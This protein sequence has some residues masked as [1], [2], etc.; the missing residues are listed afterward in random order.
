M[1]YDLALAEA[2]R[3]MVANGITT[4]YLGVSFTWEPGLRSS[5]GTRELLEAIEASRPKMAADA[6]I[7]LRF[8]IYHLEGLDTLKTW[9]ADGRLDLLSFND[10]ADYQA[11]KISDPATMAV[12]STRSGLNTEAFYNYSSKRP[13]AGKPL[14]KRL[15]N[16]RP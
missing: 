2:D 7:H 8:E 3:Q 12:Y 5:R 4:S 9:I 11:Q 13:L 14:M 6:K 16:W 15:R 1:P 10:H